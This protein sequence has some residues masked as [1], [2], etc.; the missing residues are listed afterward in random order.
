MFVFT[1]AIVFVFKS[2]V[3]IQHFFEYAN[4]FKDIFN[5]FLSC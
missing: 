2:G 5:Y 3:N 4:F 1:V